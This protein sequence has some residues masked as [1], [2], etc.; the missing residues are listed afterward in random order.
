MVHVIDSSDGMVLFQERVINLLNQ[1]KM[2]LFEV[3]LVF[4]KHINQMLTSLID[5]ASTSGQ[6][7]PSNI[8]K[9][10]ELVDEAVHSPQQFSLDKLLERA[11]HQRMDILDT[12][13]R[14]TLVEIEIEL[15]NAILM[16]RQW[17]HLIR[18]QLSKVHSPGQL[19][20]PLDIPDDW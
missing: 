7:I 20:S 14:V 8:A 15:D 16:L 3:S 4:Q 6:E 9:P 5:F 2:P 10:W 17:E 18:T 19:F 12:L 1:L 13:I 11:D